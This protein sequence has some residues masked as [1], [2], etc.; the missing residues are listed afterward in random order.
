MGGAAKPGSEQMLELNWY[1]EGS[2]YFKGPYRN[3][4]ELD[5]IAFECEDV[6]RAYH[7]LLGKGA[8]S[9]HPPFR[10]GQTLLAYVQIRT[11]F[12][13]N[14]SH[15]PRPHRHPKRLVGPTVTLRAASGSP[16]RV[17]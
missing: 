7:E 10:E 2:T 4:D 14:C 11:A 3:G 16:A 6:E 13:S 1:P 5:H 8:R 12:G 9:A 17:A 15:P